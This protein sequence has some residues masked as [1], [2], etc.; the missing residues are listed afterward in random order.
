MEEQCEHRR[1]NRR[2]RGTERELLLEKKANMSINIKFKTII[3]CRLR[4]RPRAGHFGIFREGR[5]N[6][7]RRGEALSIQRGH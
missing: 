4:I 1:M 3:T 5:R 7:L 6:D 2:N